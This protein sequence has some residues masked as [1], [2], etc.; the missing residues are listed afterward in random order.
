MKIQGGY[1]ESEVWY[2]VDPIDRRTYPRPSMKVLMK[3]R[4]EAFDRNGVL[5]ALLG[6]H[7]KLCFAYRCSDDAMTILLPC[8]GVGPSIRM[9]A[10]EKYKT[11]SQKIVEEEGEDQKA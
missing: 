2:T 10:V 8:G 4:R 3:I 5:R 1:R 6:S 7:E 9:S 11:T